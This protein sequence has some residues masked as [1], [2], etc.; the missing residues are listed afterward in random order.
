MKMQI[1]GFIVISMFLLYGC[2]EKK[3]EV[4]ESVTPISEELTPEEKFLDIKKKAEQGDAVAQSNFGWMYHEGAG[5]SKNY[6][7]AVEWLQKAAAQGDADAQ[8]HVG[9]MYYQGQGVKQNSVLAYA[10]ANLAAAQGNQG[11]VDIDPAL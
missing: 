4:K 11:A 6:A 1:A 8:N 9:W 7:K 10:W 5:V 2:G 3:G